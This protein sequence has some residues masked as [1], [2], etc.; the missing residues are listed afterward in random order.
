MAWTLIRRRL[1]SH[2][3]PQQLD[4]KGD[5]KQVRADFIG[6]TISYLWFAKLATNLVFLEVW[7]EDLYQRLWTK[8]G[9]RSLVLYLT[10]WKFEWG[11]TDMPGRGPGKKIAA[12]L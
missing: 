1:F 4:V 5:A 6:R 8:E 2:E 3:V 12:M 9:Q 7:L 10:L 11:Y